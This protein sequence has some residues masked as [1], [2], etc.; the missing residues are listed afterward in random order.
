MRGARRFLAWTGAATILAS[1][2]LCAARHTRRPRGGSTEAFEA[3]QPQHVVETGDTLWD[4]CEKITGK[5][6]IWPRVWAMNPEITNPHWIF[7]G[8]VVRFDAPTE[9]PPSR[10]ELVASNVDIPQA[11]EAQADK[12]AQGPRVEVI[13]TAPPPTR[14]KI[15]LVQKVFDGTLVTD[16]ELA[17]AGKL[18]NSLQDKVMLRVGDLVFMTFPRTKLPKV[19]DT[20][21]I[22]RTVR[23]VNHPVSGRRIGFMTEITGTA[24]VQ[25]LERDVARA[26]IKNAVTEIERGQL[27]APLRGDLM[28]SIKGTPAK[29]V[30][31]GVVVAIE[32]DRVSA[33]EQR[34]VFIDKGRRDGLERGNE[35]RVRSRGDP[36][37]QTDKNFPDID[38]ATLLLVDVRDTSSSALVLDAL[39]ELWAG[40]VVRSVGPAASVRPTR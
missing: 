33:G 36:F 19:G 30:V 35:L 12:E 16:K 13:T 11:S 6:W 24:I 7:P 26:Q 4:V 17:E 40:D 28:L 9:A 8:D 15:D 5:P 3:S 32:G 18:T 1:L 38:L 29:R 10:A 21:I 27:V 31:E 25:E 2:G 39:R 37:T 22:Y 14:N 23:Q 34:L 20:Y